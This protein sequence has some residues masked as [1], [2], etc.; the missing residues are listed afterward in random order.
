MAQHQTSRLPADA[1]SDPMAET[2][3][4]LEKVVIGLNLCPFAKAVHVKNQVRY[5]LS[6]AADPEALLADLVRELQTLHATRSDEID[7][8]LLIHPYVLKDFLEY[9]DFLHI[10]DNV[11]DELGLTGE[12]QVAS[13]HPQYQF[14]GSHVDDIEN[15][16]NRSPYP[17]LHL[18]REESVER[19]VDAFPDTDTIFEKNM[20]TMRRIGHHGLKKLLGQ[21]SNEDKI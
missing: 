11:L 18:L 2:R 1:D 8:T 17:M 13:F 3:T 19:A 21:D 7:T 15:H 12:L 6:T 10:A 14:A 9:N 16:T 4:W 20:E 5:V